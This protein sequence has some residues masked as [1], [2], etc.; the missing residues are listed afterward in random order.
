M[1]VRTG[2]LTHGMD[3]RAVGATAAQ[4]PT[5]CNQ[6]RCRAAAAEAAA[7]HRFTALL[8]GVADTWKMEKSK[9]V[10]VACTC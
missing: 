4:Q 7:G 6:V 2:N 9:Q 1:T 3:K 10:I 8:K 5:Y